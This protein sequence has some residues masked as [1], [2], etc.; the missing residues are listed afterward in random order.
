[1]VQVY[2]CWWRICGEICFFQVLISYFLRFTSIC[3]LF[4]DSPSYICLRKRF[5]V[6][7]QWVRTRFHCYW[8]KIYQRNCL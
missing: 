6:A 3:D 8:D 4:T 1:M 2:Q 7:H 5:G